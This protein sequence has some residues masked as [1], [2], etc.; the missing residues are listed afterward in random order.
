MVSDPNPPL[1]GLLLRRHEF[2]QRCLP[3]ARRADNG[4]HLA[5][6]YVQIYTLQNYLVPEGFAEIFGANLQIVR[7]GYSHVI[8]LNMTPMLD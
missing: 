4:N 7:H 1:I 5:A 3:T 2:E 8:L 6:L